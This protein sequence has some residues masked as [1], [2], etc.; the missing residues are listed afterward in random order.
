MVIREPYRN[1]CL[2]QN[3]IVESTINRVPT[4]FR[5]RTKYFTIQT[6]KIIFY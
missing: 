1:K 5:D 6:I 2:D 3:I 4:K